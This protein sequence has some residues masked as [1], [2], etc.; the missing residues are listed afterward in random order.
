MI[1]HSTLDCHV[2]ILTCSLGGPCHTLY[3][4]PR[5]TPCIVGTA[6]GV[7]T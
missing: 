6:V 4:P 7:T 1:N 5:M 3:D 2:T